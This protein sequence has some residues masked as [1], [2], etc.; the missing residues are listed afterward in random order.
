[1][2]ATWILLPFLLLPVGNVQARDIYCHLVGGG[3]LHNGGEFSRDWYVVN[4]QVRKPQLPG[5]TKPTVGCTITYS[6]L[7]PMYRPVEI[8]QKPKLGELQTG[9][10]RISYR[11]SR[12]GEDVIRVRFHTVGRTGGLESSVITYRIHVVDRPI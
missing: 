4:S 9:N 10:S 11:S 1:M 12:T 2:K 5:Q 8:L 3:V 7:G 6:S